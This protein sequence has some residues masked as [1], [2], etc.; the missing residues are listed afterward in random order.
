MN[1]TLYANI[2]VV[3][4]ACGLGIN[5]GIKETER[6]IS[7]VKYFLQYCWSRRKIH[8]YEKVKSWYYG[9]RLDWMKIFKEKKNDKRKIKKIRGRTKRDS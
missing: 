4:S 7:V 5:V 1:F 3:K 6:S 9:P 2:M 8:P